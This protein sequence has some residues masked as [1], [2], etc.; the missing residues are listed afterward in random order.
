MA[1]KKVRELQPEFDY[2]IEEIFI[3]GDSELTEEHGEKVPVIYING[4]PHDFFRVDEAR[5]R[6]ALA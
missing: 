4:K 5:F 3:D 6:K 2:S 1:T